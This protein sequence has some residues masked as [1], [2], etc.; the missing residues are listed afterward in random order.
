[1]VKMTFTDYIDSKSNVAISEKTLTINKIAEACVVDISTVYRWIN[2]KCL[3]N[4]L[5]QQKIK[6]VTGIEITFPSS[7]RI[8]K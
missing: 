8:P 5:K 7:K 4:P 6:E 3:P 1:M 2:G